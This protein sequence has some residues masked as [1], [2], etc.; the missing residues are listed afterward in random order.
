[1]EADRLGLEYSVRAGYE[2]EA[3]GRVF[4]LF[5][6]GER[7]ERDRARIEGREPRL[8][9][10]VFSSHP[11][12]DARAIQAA[13]GAANVAETPKSG[14]VVNRD[15]YLQR[16]EGIS[17]GTSK[18]QG[19]VRDNRFYHAEMGITIAFPRGWTIENE[20]DRLLAYTPSKD[21]I[22]QITAE[23]RPPNQAPREYLLQKLRGYNVARGEA[24]SSN[25]DD[26]YM[27]LTSNGSPLDGGTGPVRWAVVYH[28]KSAYVFAGASRSSSRGVPE[29]DGL[30]TSVAQTLRSLKSSEFPLAE[31][32]RLKMIKASEKSRLDDYVKDV[33]EDKYR[34]ETLELI[35]GLYPSKALTPGQLFKVIE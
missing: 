18:A 14:W 13:K 9:H 28:N 12:P 17:Y 31:P 27:V 11:S 21:A 33:P 29:A 25:G 1:M 19:I 24:F 30:I 26:G 6:A 22:M 3:M 34:R 15:P 10:G 20:R 2:P 5:K 23:A 16:I 7:F 4:D 8:Y 35:N 32:Y